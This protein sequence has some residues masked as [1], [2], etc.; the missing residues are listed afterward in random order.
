[1]QRYATFETQRYA[2]NH[3]FQASNFISSLFIKKVTLFSAVKKDECSYDFY[4]N[5]LVAF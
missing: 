3:I 1:M 5:C 2:Q 4:F